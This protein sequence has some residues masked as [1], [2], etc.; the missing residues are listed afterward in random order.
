MA[1]GILFAGSTVTTGV[2]VNETILSERSFARGDSGTYA[3]SLIG[4]DLPLDIP[5]EYIEGS[6]TL[7]IDL[8]LPLFER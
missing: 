6:N 8:V 5:T 3:A 1:A 7:R 2:V 4:E